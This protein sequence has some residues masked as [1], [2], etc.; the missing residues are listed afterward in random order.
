MASIAFDRSTGTRRVLFT[1]HDGARRTVRLGKIAEKQAQTVRTHIEHLA[2]A[3]VTGDAS[4]RGTTLWLAGIGDTLHA[5]LARVGLCEPRTP[6]ARRTLRALLDRFA[7]TTTVSASTK[8]VHQQAERVLVDHFGEDRDLDS[9]D[10]EAAD[11]W[12]TYLGELDLAQATISKRVR[13]ARQI[14]GQA[15]RWGWIDEN[16]LTGLRAGSEANPDRWAYVERQAIERVIEACP[17]DQWRAVF[18]LARFAGLRCPSEAAL[19][20][21]GDVNWEKSRI[22]VRSPKTRGHEGKGSRV[23]PMDPALRSILSKLFAEA[24]EGAERVLPRLV[25]GSI[26]LRTQALRI[27]ERAG[28]TPWPKPMHNLRASC[29][30]DW[31]EKH[32]MHVVAAWLGHSPKVAMKHY[33]QVR[34][35][36][37]EAAAGI[38]GGAQCGAPVAQYAAQRASADTG[39]NRKR[40]PQLVSAGVVTQDD[41]EPCCTTPN[42]KVA[43]P[44]FEPG[45]KRL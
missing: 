30:T 40:G 4:P 21:W 23:V 35:S 7:E 38:E 15:V 36:H 20:R 45:T 2:G 10:A 18:A 6:R 24:E 13:L 26:N 14:F 22:V 12:R 39:G 32:P 31:C 43:P 16:P 41:A 34:D 1:D 29:E 8:L 17:D 3:A 42:G 11:D 28:L 37:F 9:I 5:R 25:D 19:L 33:L 44:G 27:I